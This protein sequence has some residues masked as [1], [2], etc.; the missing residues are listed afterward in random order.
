M[1]DKDKLSSLELTLWHSAKTMPTL[2][3]FLKDSEGPG[4][5]MST[6]VTGHTLCKGCGLDVGPH[7]GRSYYEAK[8]YV[9]RVQQ[10]SQHVSKCAWIWRQSP[11]ES[12]S[13]LRSQQESITSPMPHNVAINV[14]PQVPQVG[15]R[16][17]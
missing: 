13:N 6:T 15:R 12:A 9:V 5:T 1:S 8:F 4:S 10:S 16:W 3:F 7:L 2:S 11:S 14:K 17:G